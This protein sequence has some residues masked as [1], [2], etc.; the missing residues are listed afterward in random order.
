MYDSRL[1]HSNLSFPLLRKL[2]EA[3]DKTAKKVFKDEIAKRL[4]GGNVNVIKY[5]L[6]EGYLSFLNENEIMSLENDKLK[7]LADKA[8]KILADIA[9]SPKI[10]TSKE[11]NENSRILRA[12]FN[13]SGQL[14]NR[15]LYKFATKLTRLDQ[16]NFISM[17]LTFNIFENL[18]FIESVHKR[19]TYEEISQTL[20]QLLEK[21]T[22]D[23]FY[24]D[25]QIIKKAGRF[26]IKLIL[27]MIKQ[28]GWKWDNPEW[29]FDLFDIYRKT[30]PF[31][32]K[33]AL[34]EYLTHE[35]FV[36]RSDIFSD[37]FISV[38]ELFDKAEIY[39]LI[40]RSDS[41]F[42]FNIRETPDDLKAEYLIDLKRIL[43]IPLESSSLD[44]SF[45]FN[46]SF[47]PKE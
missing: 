38:V 33:R 2:A 30:A 4:E 46:N 31:E 5:L 35:K 18:D 24:P 37:I 12:L 45:S 20:I 43:S 25:D 21:I 42:S 13:N 11:I 23:W 10:K 36:I 41:C 16:L 47:T 39:D 17:E 22:F 14:K 9:G 3:G 34:R 15:I 7:I 44:Q 6:I 1:L 40:S 32:L 26:G 27:E 29:Y 19:Y 8:I 28:G